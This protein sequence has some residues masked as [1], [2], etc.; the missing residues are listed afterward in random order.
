[1]QVYRSPS[2]CVVILTVNY[3][4]LVNL[5]RFDNSEPRYLHGHIRNC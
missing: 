3:S 2:L 1:M 5:I 4:L